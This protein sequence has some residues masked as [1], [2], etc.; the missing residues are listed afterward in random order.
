MRNIKLFGKKSDEPTQTKFKLVTERGNGIYTWD[1]KL[2]ESDIVRS[3]IRPTAISVGK[4]VPKHVRTSGG[5]VQVNPEPRIRFLLEE[6]NP[7]MS[8]QQLVEKMCRQLCLNNNAFALITRDADCLPFGMYPIDSSTVEAVYDAQN[9]LYL[10]FSM[11]NGKQYT[12]PYGDVIHLR[13]DF[14]NND[15]FGTSKINALQPLMT[16]VG[17]I[18]KSVVQ[19]VKNSGLIRWLLKYNSSMRPEDVTKQAQD[20]SDSFLSTAANGSGV[21]AVDSKADAIQVKTDDYVPNASLIDRM[22]SRMYSVFGTNEKIVQNRFNEDEWN[23]FY[24]GAV[25]PI[26]IDLGN[27]MTRKLFTRKERGF[28]NKI[29]IEASNLQY[30]SMSTKLAL[31]QMVDR[32]AMT[33][34]E[35]RETMNKAPLPGGDEAIR[36]LDTAPVTENETNGG[37]ENGES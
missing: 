37:D 26:L 13:S 10:R 19:A 14:C 30:A 36:R 27:E 5:N 3:C 21:A 15:I 17:T 7:Y 4:S 6:P 32:G 2:Y 28:G 1:G 33:P 35:W 16:V 24:E 9:N 23:A 29:V 11:R 25:E 22:T 12:F 34:N 20:F 8:F 18:D 31:S